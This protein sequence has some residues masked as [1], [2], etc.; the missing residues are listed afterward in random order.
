MTLPKSHV[1]FFFAMVEAAM[2]AAKR[3]TRPTEQALMNWSSSA[4][5]A[6][7]NQT[8]CVECQLMNICKRKLLNTV[9]VIGSRQ[10]N[11]RSNMRISRDVSTG[12]RPVFDLSARPDC[13]SFTH[14]ENQAFDQVFDRL[15]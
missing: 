14:S 10:V 8:K 3:R 9:Q 15:D 6:A 5:L 11:A 7:L 12:M 1:V 4:T 2:L 13:A